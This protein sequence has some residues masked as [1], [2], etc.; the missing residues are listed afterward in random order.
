MTNS[1]RIVYLNTQIVNNWEWI[2][3]TD[4]INEKSIFEGV[5]E[6]TKFAIGTFSDSI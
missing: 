5:S 4:V 2:V 1:W 3:R 6:A